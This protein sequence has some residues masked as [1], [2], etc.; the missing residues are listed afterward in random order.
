MYNIE[1]NYKK[2]EKNII[3]ESI[4]KQNN[5]KKIINIKLT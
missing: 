3:S 4:K 2:K 1:K 5:Y